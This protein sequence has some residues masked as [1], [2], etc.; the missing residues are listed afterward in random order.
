[1]RMKPARM[2]MLVLG[3]V[4]AVLCALALALALTAAAS[5]SQESL[6]YFKLRLAQ[7]RVTQVEVNSADK[8]MRVTEAGSQPPVYT[9]RFGSAAGLRELLV[10]YPAVTVIWASGGGASW[11]AWVP[12]VLTVLFAIGVLVVLVLIAKRYVHFGRHG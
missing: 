8:T 10:Q 3:G 11:L 9:V 7:H 2:R 1:M 12:A 4:L 5:Q 6:A